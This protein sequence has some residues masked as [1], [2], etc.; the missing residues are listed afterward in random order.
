[1][2]CCGEQGLLSVLFDP[3]YATNGFFYVNYTGLSGETR[4]ERYHSTPG[5]D[6]ADANSAKLIL[7]I[8]QPFTNHNAGHMLFG[9]WG[10]LYIPMGDGGSA[11]DPQGNGQNL[12]TLLGKL[13]RI[14]VHTSEPYR[15][16]SDNPFVGQAGARP[17]I[18][19]LGLRNPWR[20]DIDDDKLYIADVGQAQREEVNVVPIRTPAL[21]YG[22][23][24]MEGSIC[25]SGTCGS[26]YT[27]PLVEYDHSQ[28][29]A[30]IGGFVYRGTQLPEL[31]GQYFYSDLC[32][33]WVRSFTYANHL[34]TQ[35][36]QWTQFETLQQ[37][38]S[39]GVDGVGELYVI[40]GAGNVL[41]FSRR[42]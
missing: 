32:G 14:N 16:P 20:F 30:I 2:K 33:G 23:H 17:E 13:L 40:D 22:W 10:R 42:E 7:T 36:R 28:G 8:A 3:D 26:G 41:K 21:N 27:L 25:L 37:P 6:V 35:Q 12:N 4:I 5:S 11:N 18:W 29:C 15:V 34:A 31:Q 24:D 19:A 1:V 9:P 38:R 39:F